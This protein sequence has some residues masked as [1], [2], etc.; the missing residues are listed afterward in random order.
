MQ[1]LKV[2]G[3][4]PAAVYWLLGLCATGVLRPACNWEQLGAVI[5]ASPLRHTLSRR[6]SPRTERVIRPS[7]F[8]QPFNQP[9]YN[10]AT[11]SMATYVI[12]YNSS[13]MVRLWNVKIKLPVVDNSHSK[14]TYIKVSFI[15]CSSLITCTNN[16]LSLPHKMSSPGAELLEIRHQASHRKI[17]EAPS[18][19]FVTW[20]CRIS[21]VRSTSTLA[22]FKSNNLLFV[23][24]YFI[25]ALFPGQSPRQLVTA[26]CDSYL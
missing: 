14:E 6:S 1:V 25:A 15:C 23:G 7:D 4:N 19:L 11:F 2:L 20:S 21:E 13:H 22:E 10:N 18:T 16:T 24:R 12:W 8:N 17:L 9:V 3:S 26:S 5:A